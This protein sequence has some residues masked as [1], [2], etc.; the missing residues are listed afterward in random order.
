MGNNK[1][2]YDAITPISARALVVVEEGEVE[3]IIDGYKFIFTIHEYSNKIIKVYLES[4][5]PKARR[6]LK[7]FNVS[8]LKV[9]LN[10]IHGNEF[11]SLIHEFYGN[12][13]GD[14]NCEW[15]VKDYHELDY[16]EI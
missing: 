8:F 10:E 16:K 1:F 6:I 9:S 14:R 2:D 3:T 5:S 12:T 11:V 13:T 7:K 15:Q 4:D